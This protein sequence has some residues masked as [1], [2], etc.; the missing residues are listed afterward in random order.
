MLI[1]NISVTQFCGPL[2]MFILEKSV[3]GISCLVLA[4]RNNVQLG[5]QLGFTHQ[6]TTLFRQFCSFFYMKILLLGIG[7]WGSSLMLTPNIYFF[8]KKILY[9]N[10]G[11]TRNNYN[12]IAFV[13]RQKLK[14]HP[15]PKVYVQMMAM[16]YEYILTYLM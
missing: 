11:G 10:S 4:R 14:R 2:M 3:P 1:F 12:Q 16:H 7:G 5:L 6:R 8:L 13:L 9:R 15:Q